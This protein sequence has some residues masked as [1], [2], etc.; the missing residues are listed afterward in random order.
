MGDIPKEVD[1]W[2][3]KMVKLLA[4]REVDDKDVS[5]MLVRSVNGVLDGIGAGR[6]EQMSATD[7]LTTVKDRLPKQPGNYLRPEYVV[8]NADVVA[9]LVEDYFT[10]HKIRSADALQSLGDGVLNELEARI[11]EYVAELPSGVRVKRD[12]FTLLLTKSGA[13]MSVGSKSVDL[14]ADVEGK[15]SKLKL[16]TKELELALETKGDAVKFDGK[17]HVLKNGLDLLLE[18]EAR[19]GK[20]TGDEAEEKALKAKIQATYDEL[21]VRAEAS[22]KSFHAQIEYSNEEK[23]LKKLSAELKSDYDKLEAQVKVAF[24][25][26]DLKVLAELVATAEKLEGKIEASGKTSG[27]TVV[28]GE[29]KATLERL[30]AALEVISK[31]KGSDLK[32]VAALRSNYQKDLEAKAKLIYA[33]K[34]ESARVKLVAEFSTTLEKAKAAIEASIETDSWRLAA[35]ASIDTKGQG[36]AKVEALAKLGEGIEIFGSQPY[37]NVRASI[38]DRQYRVFVGISLVQPAKAKDV[39][40]V[41]E[42]AE[43]NIGKAYGVL[44]EAE[45]NPD[46]QPLVTQ[47]HNHL[48]TPLPPAQVEVGFQLTGDLP[49]VP[50]PMPP[51]LTAG[52]TIRW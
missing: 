4:K 18:L 11:A 9:K 38:D 32:F 45:F 5:Q 30:D 7:V 41:F 44:K 16:N 20:L 46:G 51:A 31:Q 33:A 15:G 12:G 2:L 39:A 43:K 36:S 40:K 47:M 52:V 1:V 6:L 22:L 21:A 29:V 34:T 24:E 26:K 14:S 19:Q 35:G 37:L 48:R 3:D 27:G 13:A 17:L 42:A 10:K 50:A 28:K 8:K 49:N 25:K 23:G